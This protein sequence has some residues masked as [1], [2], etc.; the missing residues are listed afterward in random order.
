MRAWVIIT[1]VALAGCTAQQARRAVGVAALDPARPA[2]VQGRVIA[3]FADA[4]QLEGWSKYV[5]DGS[6]HDPVASIEDSA[7][8]ITSDSSAGLFWHACGIDPAG[9]PLLRW[10]WRVSE[11][12]ATSTPLSPEFDNFP[13]RLLVGFDAGWEGTGPAGTS[14]RKKVNDYTGFDPPSRAICYTFGG[15]LA[16]SEAV[17][18]AFG[19]GRIVVINLQPHTAPPTQWQWQVRDIAAD[20]RA[21]FG[22][23]APRVMALGVGSD[24]HRLRKLAWGEF[25]DITVYPSSAAASFATELADPPLQRRAPPLVWWILS[26]CAVIATAATGWWLW[27]RRT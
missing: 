22:Q 26:L 23:P 1:V 18:A 5:V 19:E 21:I 3:D 14:F 2:P 7:L 8:R 11:N 20:Y 10:R 6:I 12:F 4:A 24:S 17:D 9:E 27:R 15:K 25:D 13:A 16:A